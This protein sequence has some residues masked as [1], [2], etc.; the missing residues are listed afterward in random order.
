MANAIAIKGVAAE[1][2]WGYHIAAT[3]RAWAVGG[4]PGAWTFTATIVQKNGFMVSKRPLFIVTPNGW[5]W[6]VETLQITDDALMATLSP[7]PQETI[8]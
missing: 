1:L 6:P 8:V 4:V 5:Q 3:L 2:R 7:Q